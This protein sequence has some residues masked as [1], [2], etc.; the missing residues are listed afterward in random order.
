MEDLDR[1]SALVLG[2]AI[3][4]PA[5]VLSRSAA[6]AMYGPDDGKEI[7]PGIRQVD[8][9]KWPV[10]FATYK[11]AVVSDYV[12]APDSGFPNEAMK[13]DMICQIVDGEIWVKQGELEYTA[14][15]GHVFACGKGTFEEDQ[16]R[17]GAVAVMR[18]IDLLP[19]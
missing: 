12:F 14:K 13:N 15:T 6:A 18:V 7:L 16:N 19:A 2:V 11:S 9:R 5:S 10:S 4:V 8:L 1:R 17:S 3:A